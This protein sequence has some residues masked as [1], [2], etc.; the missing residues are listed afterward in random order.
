M[1]TLSISYPYTLI[2]KSVKF[3][4]KIYATGR[5]LVEKSAKKKIKSAKKTT[6]RLLLHSVVPLN[7][8]LNVEHG[9]RESSVGLIWVIDRVGESVSSV[10]EVR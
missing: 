1:R 7:R 9:C 5:D 2:D 4:H 6:S 8:M 3:Q 10:D